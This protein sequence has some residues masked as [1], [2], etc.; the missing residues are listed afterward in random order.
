M[1]PNLCR[2]A[3]R[4]RGALE[5]F[6]LTLVFIR[7][8]LGLFGRLT[9]WAIVPPM[10][11]LA[12]LCWATGGSAWLLLAPLPLF[13]LIQAPFTLIG[14]RLLFVEGGTVGMALRATRDALGVLFGL[15]FVA[16]LG[17]IFSVATCGYGLIPVAAALLYLPETALLERVPLQ[18]AVGR[19]LRLASGQ[20]GAA[21]AGAVA[22]VFL[23]VWCALVAEFGGQ[24]VVES[25]LQLGR[26]FGGLTGGQVTP[27]L[28][29]GALAAQPLH[30]LYRLLLYVDVRTR[31][32]GWDLQVALRAAAIARGAA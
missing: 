9:A 19:S 6:D 1:N 3:L 20:G 24:L 7:A 10:L 12:P 13:P 8:N 15:Q 16:A 30:A 5:V 28:L 27:F 32:E 31:R 18:R 22:R 4:P 17:A 25:T 2:V 26:P 23:T 11:V 29:A 14:G 21:F